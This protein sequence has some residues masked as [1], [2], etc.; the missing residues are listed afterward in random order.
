[1][2][3]QLIEIKYISPIYQCITFKKS[4]GRIITF[5]LLQGKNRKQSTTKEIE[6]HVL[7]ALFKCRM[8]SAD[9]H[10]SLTVLVLLFWFCQISAFV[11]CFK[12]TLEKF[13]GR[14][15]RKTFWGNL[16]KDQDRRAIDIRV[17]YF[18]TLYKKTLPTKIKP[19]VSAACPFIE[20][21][22]TNII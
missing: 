16:K 22:W 1:M 19:W 10:T 3:N 7:H 4:C 5:L 11:V 6:E 21:D 14:Q 18:P 17:N 15:G 9:E 2:V 13:P 8:L 12:V 20:G